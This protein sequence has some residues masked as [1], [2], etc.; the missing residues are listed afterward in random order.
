MTD[1]LIAECP[2]C[3]WGPQVWSQEEKARKEKAHAERLHADVMPDT[4]EVC[5][6]I[7]GEHPDEH[8]VI[9]TAMRE[10]AGANGGI[11]DPNRVR[12]RLLPLGLVRPQV[13]SAAYRVFKESGWLVK[14]DETVNTDTRS[15]N[16]GKPQALYRIDESAHNPDRNRARRTA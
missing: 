5:A 3:R 2:W 1:P 7:L 13:L 12:E 14:V 6:R 15:G 11:V 9:V 16:A 10:D 8:E 4:S